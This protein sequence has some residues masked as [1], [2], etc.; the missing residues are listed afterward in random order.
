MQT[1]YC[2]IKVGTTTVFGNVAFNPPLLGF[3][4]PAIEIAVEM[5]YGPEAK[6]VD[7]EMDE[8]DDVCEPL[9]WPSYI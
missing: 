5:L 6:L 8:P 3:T 1:A 2:V 7:W 9:P 4:R